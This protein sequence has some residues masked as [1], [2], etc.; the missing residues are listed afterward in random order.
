MNAPFNRV[1]FVAATLILCFRPSQAQV[2]TKPVVTQRPAWT[3]HSDLRGMWKDAT[4]VAHVKI[5]DGAVLGTPTDPRFLPLVYTE[6]RAEVVRWFKGSVEAK[7]SLSFRQSA[8][9]L[10]LGDKIVVVEGREA[11]TPNAEYIVFLAD[12]DH[13]YYLVDDIEGAFQL[14]KGFVIAKGFGRVAQTYRKVDATRFGGELHQLMREV[15]R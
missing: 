1:L 6:F 11:L 3:A 13:Q 5:I 7:S 12:R 10:D 4:V 15:G 8:G 9:A 2:R 14:E